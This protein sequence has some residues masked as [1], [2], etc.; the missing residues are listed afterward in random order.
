MNFTER[1]KRDREQLEKLPDTRSKLTFIWDY[2]K[3][4]IIAA[5]SVLALFVV[6]L[7]SN[8]GRKDASMYVVLLNNDSSLRECDSSIFDETLKKTD[9]DLKGKSVDVNDKL[10]VSRAENEAEDIE[11]MQILT[12]L[13]T[14]SDLDL[15]VADK[16][17]FDYFLEDG[18]YVDLSL[19]IDQKLLDKYKDDLY[20]WDDPNGQRIL[21]GIVLHDDSII[22]KAG[23][24][25][26]DVIMGVV[27]NAS[28]MDVAIEFIRQLLSDRN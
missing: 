17:Y 10:S 5:V 20:Y 4:P 28:N 18:G 1:L 23:Y 15:Y 26:D 25:H 14:I 22:H 16:Q 27:G 11:T 9:I 13:F 3:I 12:A 6:F 2:Y 8:I 21:C 7:I 24:Y 19:L